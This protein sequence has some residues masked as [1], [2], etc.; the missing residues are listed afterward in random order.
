MSSSFTCR[1]ITFL[2]KKKNH[3]HST[4]FTTHST[5]TFT[6]STVPPFPL[7]GDDFASYLLLSF[8]EACITVSESPNSEGGVEPEPSESPDAERLFFTDD[9]SR[10]RSNIWPVSNVQC[11]VLTTEVPGLLDAASGFVS[12]M[13]RGGSLAFEPIVEGVD[14]EYEDKDWMRVVQEEWKPRLVGLA[15]NR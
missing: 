3:H 11:R 9:G 7:S 14:K 8:P 15:E 13:T 2:P 12:L 6:T 1:F 4:L 5:A 10:T